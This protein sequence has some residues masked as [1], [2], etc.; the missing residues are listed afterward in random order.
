MPSSLS[1][2]PI[3]LASGE[4]VRLEAGSI[5]PET[6]V[7]VLNIVGAKITAAHIAGQRQLLCVTQVRRPALSPRLS[8][9]PSFSRLH[10]PPETSKPRAQMLLTCF[11]KCPGGRCCDTRQTLRYLGPRAASRASEADTEAERDNQQAKV[12][13]YS[14][15]L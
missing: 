14:T 9:E 15:S 11:L 3:K 4:L 13:C 6:A 12:G 2:E 7:Y 5:L 10:R 8:F 1:I